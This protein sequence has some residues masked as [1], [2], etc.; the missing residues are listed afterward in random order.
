MIFSCVFWA[1][2]TNVCIQSSEARSQM[3]EFDTELSIT[4]AENETKEQQL[5]KESTMLV[6]GGVI[7]AVIIAFL[8]VL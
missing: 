3:N 5:A 7:A 6:S 4:Y 1:V 2:Y 8:S